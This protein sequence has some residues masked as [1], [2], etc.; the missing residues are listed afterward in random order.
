MRG[1]GGWLAGAALALGL[2]LTGAAYAEVGD[3]G[4]GA[5][6][7]VIEPSAAE[8]AGDA[9]KAGAGDEN[10]EKA[11]KGGKTAAAKKGDAD[12]TQADKAERMKVTFAEFCDGWIDKLRERERYNISKIKWETSPDGAVVGEYVGYDTTTPG[13]Q[14]VGNVDTTP[15]GKLVYMEFRLRRSG[16]SKEE[17]LAHEPEI[18]ERTEVTEIFRFDRSGWVY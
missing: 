2:V 7:I 17:A 12:E 15:I 6:E 18:V 5:V 10:K 11:K 3:A 14:T 1:D 4:A 9:A 13:P 16:K 8:G